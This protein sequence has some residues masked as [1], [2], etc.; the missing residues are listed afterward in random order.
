MHSGNVLHGAYEALL[1]HF[2]PQHW[3]PAETPFEVIVGA[4]LTQNT[5]WK[6]V[7]RALENLGVAPERLLDSPSPA[8]IALYRL[9]QTH[10][11]I[12][13]DRTPPLEI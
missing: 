10:G 1:D 6:N 7:D 11:Y 4:V 12:L 5:S 2:G 9:S 13:L 3:W 8:A